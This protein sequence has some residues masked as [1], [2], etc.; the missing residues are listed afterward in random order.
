MH[1]N[2]R[3]LLGRIIRCEAGGEGDNGMRAVASVVMNRVHVS[4][5]EYLRTGG[6]DLHNVIFQPGQFDCARTT[7]GGVANPQNIYNMAAEPVHLQI[8]DWAL[9]GNVLGAVGDCLWYFNPFTSTCP[10]TFP[11]NGSGTFHTKINL[12]CFYRPTQ[13]YAQT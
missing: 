5:G 10:Q 13:K 3:E 4:Y 7:I 8:A 1:F 11:R 2:D 12:H 6:G 9:Q